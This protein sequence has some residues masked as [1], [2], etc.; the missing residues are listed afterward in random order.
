MY[1][2]V[3][4]YELVCQILFFIKCNFTLNIDYTLAVKTLES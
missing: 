4:N 2:N 1:N 3:F